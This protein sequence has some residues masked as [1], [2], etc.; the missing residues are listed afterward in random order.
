MAKGIRFIVLLF[1]VLFQSNTL[2]AQ[3]ENAAFRSMLDE[4]FKPFYHGVASGDPLQNSVVIWTRVTPNETQINEVI[5]VKWHVSLDTSFND[6]TASGIYSTDL[7]RDFTVKIDVQGLSPNQYYFYEFEALGKKSII[8]RTKTAPDK[9]TEVNQLRFATVSCSNYQAGYFNVYDKIFERNDIDAVIHLGD[10]IYEYGN[11]PN[12]RDVLPEN[13]I[14]ALT[15]YRL[16]H[17]TYKLDEDSRKMHQQYPIISTWDDHESANNAW[18]DGAEN[19]DSGEGNWT[20][21]KDNSLQA[22]YEWMPLRQPDTT[23]FYRIWRKLNYGDL[24]DLFILD[25]RLY[26]RDEQDIEAINDTA[27]TLIGE[28]QMEWLKNGLVSSTAKWKILAQQV[29]MAPLV[30]P[31]IELTLND[32]QWDGYIAERKRLYDIILENNVENVVVLT[33][34]IHTSW[35]ND[36]PYNK[37]NYGGHLPNKGSVAVEFVTTSVTS[38][39]FPFTI[40]TDLYGIV[41]NTLKH[42]RYVDVTRKGYG[43]LDLT[44]DRASNDFYYVNKVNNPNA[45]ET[46]VRTY[47]NKSGERFLRR[48]SSSFDATIDFRPSKYQAPLFPDNIANVDTTDTT[49][50]PI[51]NGLITLVALHPNPFNNQFGIQYNLKE[52]GITSFH[53]INMEGKIVFSKNIG[54]QSEGLHNQYIN[55]SQIP[56]GN[57][58]LQVK[59]GKNTMIFNVTKI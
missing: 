41:K 23:N 24:A 29:M 53:L 48:D 5:E 19:H 43:L 52:K 36:L 16:R 4:Q 59:S 47:Y 2:L 10:Y 9:N 3:P 51:V 11:L 54:L 6:I 31:I 37:D 56:S 49:A 50:T 21:R 57:Y 55:T 33:G 32:D 15:D 46:Y 8:G 34:D 18:R 42:V 35:A 14:V 28:E 12:V 20:D 1:V 26:D 17:S 22:Y 7:S 25:T 39:S 13:E 38:P 58:K 45:T 40:P 44:P 30:I 27:R